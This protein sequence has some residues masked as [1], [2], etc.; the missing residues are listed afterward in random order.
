M[1]I[2][3]FTKSYIIKIYSFFILISLIIGA[4]SVANA[5]AFSV[6]GD[7]VVNILGQD[8]QAA[9]NPDN[10]NSD[11]NLQSMQ[12]LET[13]TIE[14]NAKNVKNNSMTFASEGDALLPFENLSGATGSETETT[15]EIITYEVQKGDTLSE[16]ADTYG[17]SMNTI[18]WENNLKSKVLKEGQKLSI[19]PVT[20][21]KHIIKK[22]DTLDKIAAKYDADVDEVMIYNDVTRSSSLK[23]G[24]ILIIP[25]GIIKTVVVV[26]SKPSGI[27]K[28]LTHDSGV[29]MESGYFIR[30][31]LG[32]VTS[33][34]GSR[35]GS[36]HAGV[37]I[38]NVRGTA[39]VAAAEGKI[40]EVIGSC[41][42]GRISCG[43]KY[44]NYIIIEHENGLFTRYAHLSKVK[45]SIGDEVSKGEL[46]GAMGNTGRSTG[47]HLHF[48]IEKSNGSTINPGVR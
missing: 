11:F 48:Q 34:Y 8:T 36:F 43:G 10:D 29:K 47:S 31:A 18:I 9:E 32:P 35:K 30:P 27:K 7:L 20:G 12:L 42:E 13:N 45:V 46:I 5:S 37:D 4:P 19:L 41:V 39:I 3:I 44:G 1:K 24:E 38:G 26:A 33:P 6:F 15:G 2:S 28:T 25:N 17:L 23:Q 16:I 21:V 40:V 14:S 22:G